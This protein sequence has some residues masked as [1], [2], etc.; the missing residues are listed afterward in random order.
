[1]KANK[2]LP[3]CMIA[4]VFTVLAIGCSMGPSDE[5][6][7]QAKLQ[8]HYA[9]L[10]TAQSALQQLREEQATLQASIDEIEAVAATRRTDEQKQQLED[11]TAQATTLTESVTTAYDGYQANLAEFLTLGL[12]DFPDDP[13]TVEGMNLY[14]DEAIVNSADT[15]A[16]SGDYKKALD[17]LGT[18]AGYYGM[19]GKDVYQPLLEKQAELDEQRFITKER[20]DMVKRNMTQDRVKEIAGVP[21]YRNIHED[22]KTKIVYW[23]YPK[24]EGGASAIYFNKSNKVYNT[25]FDAVKTR[26]VE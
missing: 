14:A 20:F 24:R 13:T 7:A 3:L 6:L 23:L 18:A 15:V 16:K 2:H 9:G 4:L 26:V 5:E 19:I 22:E 11:L 12:N 10:N 21:Y 1:M 8:E 25:N 17:L